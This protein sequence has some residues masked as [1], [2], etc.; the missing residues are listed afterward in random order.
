M[1]EKEAL[2]LL[3]QAEKKAKYTGWFGANKLDEA[4]DLYARAANAFKLA[5]M[6][7]EAGD[8]FLSQANVLLKMGE[9]DEAS[10]AYLNASKA[11][12]KTHPLDAI[13]SLQQAVQLLTEKGRF[14]AAASNQKQIAEIY[15]TDVGDLEK[16]MVAFETA[17]EWYSGED[18]NAQADAC[19]LKVA[20]FA[21]Q[22]QRYEDAIAKFELVASHSVDNKLTK[23]SV[24]D[25]L[26]KS[27]LC[28]LALG[29]FVRA[30]TSFERYKQMDITF[31]S[32]REYAFLKGLLE[33]VEAGD[34]E[35]FTGLVVD[36]DR[37]TKLDS[38]KTTLLLTIKK[39][40]N[41]EDLT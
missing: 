29:D 39:S 21:A 24:R 1:S 35:A 4:A 30:S 19:L 33:A 27:G 8:S 10:S 22:L 9:K 31:E 37:L 20:T 32:T 5:K 13:N 14:S 34:V 36:F 18:S 15:E 6:W 7:K 11:F 40:I 12:K 23:W 25:Y 41:E 26:F 16:A 28:I 2:Q 17:A 38:W 3:D